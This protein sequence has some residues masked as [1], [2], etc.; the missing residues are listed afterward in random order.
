MGMFFSFLLS[1]GLSVATK[2]EQKLKWFGRKW[3]S[4]L[5]LWKIQKYV[6]LRGKYR[7]WNINKRVSFEWEEKQRPRIQRENVAR[8]REKIR[9]KIIEMKE[10]DLRSL[11]ECDATNFVTVM[12]WL[13]MRM[14]QVML[15][16][17]GWQWNEDQLLPIKE[18]NYFSIESRKIE[19]SARKIWR[20]RTKEKWMNEWMNTESRNVL[21][22]S[23]NWL[24]ECESH[25]YLIEHQ[26]IAQRDGRW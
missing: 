22:M 17:S 14:W 13:G 7:K 15:I 25:L 16:S 11:F 6:I 9:G 5:D 26:I 23:L 24:L 2:A 3:H 18:I 12:C 1:V 21:Q 19:R 8:E 4:Y 20:R 10:N